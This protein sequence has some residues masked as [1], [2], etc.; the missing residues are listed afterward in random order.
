MPHVITAL[1]A[2]EEDCVE[3]YPVDCFIPNPKN[4]TNWR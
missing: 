3:V 2:R 1:C 4:N